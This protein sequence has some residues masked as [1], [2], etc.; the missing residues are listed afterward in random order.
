MMNYLVFYCSTF[1]INLCLI[2]VLVDEI[3]DKKGP[4]LI[5]MPISLIFA[6]LQYFAI[7]ELYVSLILIKK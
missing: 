6:I 2:V 7:L 3:L 1:E 5:H 4:G